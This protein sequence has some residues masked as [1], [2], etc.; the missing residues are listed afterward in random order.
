MAKFHLAEKLKKT[1]RLSL[2]LRSTE[3]DGSLNKPLKTFVISF[4]VYSQI[5]KP[6]TKALKLLLYKNRFVIYQD[7]EG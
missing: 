2:I 1:N 7:N 4:F 5:F 6:E 3:K